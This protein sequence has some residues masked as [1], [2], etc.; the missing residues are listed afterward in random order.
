MPVAIV[1]VAIRVAPVVSAMTVMSMLSVPV[2]RLAVVGVPMIMDTFVVAIAV[3]VV[4]VQFSG[5]GVGSH[6]NRVRNGVG[7]GKQQIIVPH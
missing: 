2:G 1:P 3:G 5:V 7:N 6:G 4:G